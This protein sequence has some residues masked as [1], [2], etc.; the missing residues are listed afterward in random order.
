MLAKIKELKKKEDEANAAAGGL[1]SATRV[2]STKVIPLKGS[3]A[4]LVTKKPV[5]TKTK[6]SNDQK[7][8]KKPKGSRSKA[9]KK[10]V[11]ESVVCLE[12]AFVAGKSI[13]RN[14]A[15]DMP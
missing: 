6:L 8:R 5:A 10:G 11:E 2:S 15:K 4:K 3:A 13:V 7:L 1:P 12:T 14:M 9:L